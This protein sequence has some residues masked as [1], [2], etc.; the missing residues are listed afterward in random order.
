MLKKLRI[1]LSIQHVGE[2][3]PE[4]ELG[5]GNLCV[6][7]IVEASDCH[8]TC[9]G[10]PRSVKTVVKIKLAFRSDRCVEFV[11]SG[12]CPTN[13]ARQFSWLVLEILPGQILI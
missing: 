5:V 12:G 9:C 10:A 2:L 7:N 8:I 6:R 13:I 3:C 1:F 4:T 11:L